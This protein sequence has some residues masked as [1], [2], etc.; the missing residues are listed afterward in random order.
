MY[1]WNALSQVRNVDG[2]KTNPYDFAK[3]IFGL[4]VIYCVRLSLNP[5]VSLM[6]WPLI[7]QRSDY[8]TRQHALSASTI[9]HAVAGHLSLMVT[10]APSTDVS[11]A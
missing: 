11:R 2:T 7:R 4:L 1:D 9:P 10:R 6:V 3:R 8:A 5:S